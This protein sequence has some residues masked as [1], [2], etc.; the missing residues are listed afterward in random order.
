[1]AGIFVRSRYKT[2]DGKIFR[3]RIQPETALLAFGSQQ[4]APP[5]GNPTEK[6]ELRLRKSVRETGITSRKIAVRWVSDIPSGYK[7]GSILYI[8]VL[9]PEIFSAIQLDQQ[10]TYLAGTIVVISKLGER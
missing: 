10:G 9:T 7:P 6:K 4:N 5:V 1:M 3:C 8:P 2:D